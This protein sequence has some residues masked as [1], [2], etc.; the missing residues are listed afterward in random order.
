VGA[1]D[2]AAS[3]HVVAVDVIVRP[4]AALAAADA[5]RARAPNPVPDRQPPSPAAEGAAVAAGGSLPASVRGRLG[6]SPALLDVCA[7][8]RSVTASPPSPYS[9]IAAAPAV[10]Y[11][12]PKYMGS[13]LKWT[14]DDRV[15]LCRAYLEMSEDPVTFTSRSKNQLWAAVHQKGT[16]VMTK[17]GNLRVNRSV[18]ALEKQFKKIPMGVSVFTSHYLAV[19]KMQTTGNLTEEDIMSGAVARYCSLDI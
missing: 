6:P 13:S 3:E 4:A 14:D 17:K 9:P 7:G 19:K 1:D 15:P 5:A 2:R 12:L 16:D 10:T 8:A 11:N 18:S